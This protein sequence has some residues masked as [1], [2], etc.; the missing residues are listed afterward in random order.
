[1]GARCFKLPGCA[2]LGLFR[3]CWLRMLAA[4]L[5][6]CVLLR[7]CG[8]RL[9]AAGQA[10]MGREHQQRYV[11]AGGGGGGGGACT[12]IWS[13]AGD[14]AWRISSARVCYSSR[15]SRILQQKSR[16]TQQRRHIFGKCGTSHCSLG[17]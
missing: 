3:Q 10:A 7:L 4:L 15:F 6:A 16:T 13:G 2:L 9:W 5:A 1:M 11:A 8:A 12:V 17:C 14:L